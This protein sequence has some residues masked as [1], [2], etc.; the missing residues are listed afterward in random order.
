MEFLAAHPDCV[1]DF[2]Y[3][4]KCCGDNW[5]LAHWYENGHWTG[6]SRGIKAT[7]NPMKVEG[8]TRFYV[9]D[10]LKITKFVVTRTFT[11]WEQTL[12]KSQS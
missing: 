8:Q 4:P 9:S 2:H 10:D 3:G 5:V 6:D 11:E 7:G 1:V 12:E